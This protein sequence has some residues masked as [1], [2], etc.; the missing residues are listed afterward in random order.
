MD[1]ARISYDGYLVEDKLVRIVQEVVGD[2]FE[3][4]QTKVAEGRRYK[5]D[6]TYIGTGGRRVCVEF[7]GARHY[8]NL[9]TI[10]SDEEK[11]ALAASQGHIVIRIPYW[12][13]L[14]DQT[15]K[16]YFGWDAEV[17]QDFQH[18]FIA[19]TAH[20]PSYYCELGLQRF[21][22]ELESLPISVRRDVVAS[23]RHRVGDQDQK[24]VVPDSLGDL[25][26]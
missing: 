22:N 15:V 1:I 6:C 21:R 16:H 10:K 24:W 11:N 8:T 5:W 14:T 12:V 7:D 20:S 18:G 26:A 25:I 19:S 23:L 3:G 9:R 13:Q 2:R 17:S 4:K